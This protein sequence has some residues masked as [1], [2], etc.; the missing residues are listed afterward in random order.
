MEQDFLLPTLD[1][2]ENTF[3]LRKHVILY[4]VAHLF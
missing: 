3:H 1:A 2:E 4:V